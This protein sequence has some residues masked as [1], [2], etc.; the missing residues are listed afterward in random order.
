MCDMWHQTPNRPP[1]DTHHPAVIT[2]PVTG[3]K[4]LNVNIGWCDGFAEL[5]KAESG[6]IKNNCRA[7]ITTPLLLI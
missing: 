1:L 7:S 2:H 3:L 5:N 4:A 6:K